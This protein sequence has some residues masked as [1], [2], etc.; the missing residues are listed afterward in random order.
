MTKETI[1]F[2][3]YPQHVDRHT[4][5]SSDL[6]LLTKEHMMVIWIMEPGAAL[7]QL[8]S[9]LFPHGVNGLQGKEFGV[10]TVPE[11]SEE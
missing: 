2:D 1:T 4:R 9:V 3:G 11:E 6:H 8:G 10:S 5:T 7:S